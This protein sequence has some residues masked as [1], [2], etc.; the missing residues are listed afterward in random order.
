MFVAY[1]YFRVDAEQ[2][3]HE[4]RTALR[5]QQFGKA[6]ELAGRI[7]STQPRYA[8]ALLLAATAA[9]EQGKFEAAVKYCKAVPR[10]AG[11][12]YTDA[13]CMAA[14]LNLKFLRR[15]SEAE[16]LYRKAVATDS[17]SVA[18]NAAMVYV[19]SIQTR[20]LE[21]IPFQLRL[22]RRGQVSPQQLLSLIQGDLMF[23]DADL[24]AAFSSNQPEHSGL[25]LAEARIATLSGDHETADRRLKDAVKYQPFL[26]EAIAR[27]GGALLKDGTE[28]QLTSWANSLAKP[29]L[30]HS[31]VWLILGQIAQRQGNNSGAARCFWEAGLRNPAS[32]KA[33]YLLGQQL[34]AMGM[35]DDAKPFLSRANELEAYRRL[36]DRDSSGQPLP[37]TAE[38]LRLA[39]S[40]A[41][42][43]GLLWEA[44]GLAVLG[45]QA[46]ASADWAVELAGRLQSQLS[47]L[48]L[49]RMAPSFDLFTK[50]D[51][52]HYAVPLFEDSTT[53]TDPSGNEQSVESSARFIDIASE[54]GLSFEY[55]NGSEPQIAGAQRPFDFTGGGIGVIDIDCDSWPDLYFAQGCKLDDSGTNVI[56]GTPNQLFRNLRG[57]SSVDIN[58]LCLLPGDVGYSQGVA[59]GDLN[60]DGFPDVYVSNIGRNLLLQNN[61]DGTFTDISRQICND[62]GR[63]S[64]SCLVCDLNSDGI[65]DLYTVN[66]LSGEVLTRI[67]RDEDGRKG[68]CAPQSFP[69]AQDQI[70]F[71]DGAGMFV[72]A[73]SESGIKVDNGKGLGVVAGDLDNDGL[74]DLF[75]ANDG[76]PNF[77]FTM[78]SAEHGFRFA[79]SAMQ[80]GV[81]VNGDGLS[82]ACMGVV[83]DDLNGDLRPDMFVTNFLDESN[84]LYQGLE[85]EGFFTDNTWAVDS[86]LGPASLSMLGFGAQAVDGDMDGKLD[87]VV[88]NGHVDDFSDQDVPYE[89][90]TQYFQNLGNLRFA[91]RSADTLGP[92][93]TKPRLG[94]SVVKLDWDNDGA[95]DVAVGALDQPVALLANRTER[96]GHSLSFELRAIS[97][98]RDSIG[99]KIRMELDG[100][101]VQRQLT[102]GDG[103]LASNDRKMLFAVASAITPPNLTL[104]WPSGSVQTFKEINAGQHWIAVEGRPVLYLVPR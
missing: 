31:D 89:M 23:V 29:V 19:L 64:T 7:S 34:A 14:N 9:S 1:R 6:E 90:P 63:W 73:T 17:E 10:D 51:L 4:A 94:R 66:Y 96:R 101:V 87:L 15:I 75:V 104:T 97:S 46:D 57:E 67:C 30:Q 32:R 61:G 39:A 24:I 95:E 49:E 70:H 71:G 62:A 25:L 103:Y 28:P 74:L 11:N 36:F 20:H 77:L 47:S 2:L 102:A 86:R 5:K 43:V 72:D 80:R 93:F 40:Q 84:T 56:S 54:V 42:A 50:T 82:E 45:T 91:E 33:H 60:N 35:A 38:R 59:V 21:L 55:D 52:T 48:P 22:I 58:E 44:F 18:T 8:D 3:L 100:T 79:E 27:W 53:K 68:S 13:L 81:A 12:L 76:V 85:I 99:A 69:G 41:E 37:L 16:D 65:P 88:A 98:Q 92:F 83:V 26:P 78:N